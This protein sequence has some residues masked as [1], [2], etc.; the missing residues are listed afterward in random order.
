[1]RM[2]RGKVGIAMPSAKKDTATAS[3]MTARN[4]GTINA[5]ARAFVFSTPPR[6]HPR[7]AL[8]RT[9]S[10]SRIGNSRARAN[11]SLLKTS[12]PA[13]VNAFQPFRGFG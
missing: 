2:L 11:L 3:S 4:E 10:A 13:P 7:H 5:N 12:N 1:M 6:L 9:N 8:H